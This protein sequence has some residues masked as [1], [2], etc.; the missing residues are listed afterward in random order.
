MQINHQN[1]KL[2]SMQ[3]GK[4]VW[5]SNGNVIEKRLNESLNMYR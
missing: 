3:Y 5:M 1:D 4:D 2:F